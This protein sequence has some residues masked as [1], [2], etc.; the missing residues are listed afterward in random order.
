MEDEFIIINVL[1]LGFNTNNMQDR[2]REV[3]DY[4][5]KHL[6]TPGGD[7]WWDG[8]RIKIRTGPD[9]TAFALKFRIIQ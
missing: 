3:Q 5:H 6:G 2:I 4:L 9:A 7:W 8:W 1:E